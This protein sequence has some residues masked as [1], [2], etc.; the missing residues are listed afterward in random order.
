MRRSPAAWSLAVALAGCAAPDDE[1]PPV[2]ATDDSAA[3]GPTCASAGRTL[4][5]DA[6]SALL[7]P[8]NLLLAPD[9]DGGGRGDV[10]LPWSDGESHAVAIVR[11]ESESLVPATYVSP[12]FADIVGSVGIAGDLDADGLP[13][14]ALGEA[15]AATNEPN[16]PS[17]AMV[18]WWSVA[19]GVELGR[20]LAYDEG[21]TGNTW[22]LPPR[23]LPDLD[24]DGVPEVA[25]GTGARVTLLSG[26]RV[27]G[28]LGEADAA[29]VLTGLA[30]SN[31]LS[32]V[33]ALHDHDHD[34]TGDLLV[35]GASAL[36]LLD[37]ATFR[38]GGTLA[39]DTLP[40]V[41]SAPARWGAPLEALALDVDGDGAPELFA[42]WFDQLVGWDGTDVL[43]VRRGERDALSLDD[44]HLTA[45]AV[46]GTT[47]GAYLGVHLETYTDAACL[48]ALA[49]SAH[50]AGRVHLLDNATLAAGGAVDLDAVAAYAMDGWAGY[51]LGGGA[52]FDGDGGLDLVVGRPALEGSALAIDLL[53]GP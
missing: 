15:V 3:P 47:S 8:Y 40:L 25:L 24:G 35:L 22:G 5:L 12:V 4:P 39:A 17:H 14:L 27:A 50:F 16:G 20:F 44:A 43:A 45:E 1:V 32:N 38:A 33:R 30:D 18:R 19:R 34:G 9:L 42:T 7:T 26:A 53:L 48:P 49:V 21:P 11:G 46:G 29:L 37:A 10:V 36:H 2:P 28:E 41:L 6:G 23:P 52:D 51:G 31:G 13:E